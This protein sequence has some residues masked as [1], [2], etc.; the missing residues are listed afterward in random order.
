MAEP[1][2]RARIVLSFGRFELVP[3]ERLLTEDGVRVEL[4]ARSLAV[5]IALASHPNQALGKRELMAEV[6][7]DVTV[8]EG[9]LR[10][11]MAALRKAL[12]EGKDGA[13]YIATLAGRGYC[14]VAPV[15]R[16]SLQPTVAAA[17]SAE[18]NSIPARSVRMVGRSVGVREIS[19]QLMASRFV[20]IVG[21]GGVGKTTV[22]IAV[23]HELLED[24]A[25]DV[26]FV[27]LGTL[28]DPNMAPAFA[29][30]TLGVAVSSD[31]PL[32]GLI[33]HLRDKRML[34]IL[35]NCEHVIDAVARLAETI[36]MASPRLHILATSRE[37]LRIEGE[38]VH[39]LGALGVPPDEPGLTAEAALTFPAIQLFVE[40]V[41]ASGFPLELTDADAAT[42][43]DICRKLGGV[44]LAIE[45][46]AG[47]V[48]AYGLRQTALLLDRHFSLQWSGQRNAPP[49]QKTLQATLDWSYGLLSEFERGVFRRLAVFVGEFSLEA[50]LAVL[51]GPTLPQAPLF[52]AFDS[53]A[54]KSLVSGRPIG[55]T[56]RYR[57]L[58]TT[59]AYA[60]AIP[61]EPSEFAALSAR[62]AAHYRQWLEETG[63]EWANLSSAAELAPYVAGLGNV[64]AAL[65]WGFGAAGDVEVGFRLAA[66]AAPVFLA[67]SLLTECRRWSESALLA[68]TDA[69]R[70]GSEEM[71]LQAAL[72]LSLMFTKGNGEGARGALARGLEL[73][74][75]LDDLQYQLQLLGALHLFHERIGEF[76]HSLG[77]AERSAS[78]ARALGDPVA[79][80]AAHSWL[81]ISQHLMGNLAPAHF[82]LEKALASP[83]ISKRFNTI[84]IGF[85]YHNRARITLARNL[86]L[87][88][89][90]DQAALVARETIEEAAALEHPVTLCMALIWAVTVFVWRRDWHSVEETIDR[91][92]RV[93]DRHSL[94][95]YQAAGRGVKGE[96]SVRRGELAVGIAALRASLR[97]LGADRYELLTSELVSALAEALSRAGEADEALA[98]I[99]RAI[100]E[101]ERN[102]RGFTMPELLRIQGEILATRPRPDRRAAELCLER[103]L[104][105]S[106][107][108]GARGW[109]LRAAVDL[110]SLWAGEGRFFEAWELLRPVLAGFTEGAETSDLEAAKHL[111]ATLGRR[112]PVDFKSSHGL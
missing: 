12:G 40:H 45:L 65:E 89:Y 88:G 55:A 98:T 38:N 70:G 82:H 3:S 32:P 17:P 76:S 41:T 27:D 43:A 67:I 91:F 57:L 85:E 42:A 14:F 81:G 25:G 29:A 6:W 66:A 15:T 77:F 4:G 35:D 2:A 53:L 69:T 79:I 22:A 73:A 63:P 51:T 110:A 16:S 107:R 21:P 83:R 30:S 62:H 111:L 101:A 56:M 20:T 46:A 34:L 78:V 31:D 23:A 61:I 50:A 71:R 109:E 103:S 112:K 60:L 94:A 24:F 37:A 44:A 92:I 26:V 64:R 75:R 11:H 108:Q 9:A 33:A 58:D 28:S 106:R 1:S 68:M 96:L 5:L 48:Q 54:A 19:A 8:D 10:F 36:F 52:A 102:G 7:P 86:W 97:A 80:A 104:E 99:E 72:G 13:R 39:W 93:A 87:R 95:P 59:R 105:L 74:E 18:A 90:P 49:R 84:Q 100:A 47:R